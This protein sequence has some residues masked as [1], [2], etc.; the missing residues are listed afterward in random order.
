MNKFANCNSLVEMYKVMTAPGVS[1]ASL[2]AEEKETVYK[3]YFD[4]NGPGAA[5]LRTPLTEDGYKHILEQVTAYA[6]M[7]YAEA[8]KLKKRSKLHQA[9]DTMYQ[10]TANAVGSA[11]VRVGGDANEF[12]ETCDTSITNIKGAL[13][14]VLTLLDDLTGA[15][16]LKDQLMTIIYRNTEGIK[17]RR[18]F[19][20]CA[21]E[22]RKA[23]E[24][25]IRTLMALNPDEQ[26][27]KT[28]VALRYML[29]EDEEGKP[30]GRRSIFEV[31]ANGIVWICKKVT[32]KLREWFGTDAESNIFGS[33]GAAI[34][35]V[36]GVACGIIKDV[37]KVA[38]H[39]V[40][41]VGSYVLSALLN[42][43]AWVVEKISGWA[44]KAKA[45]FTP[46]DKVADDKLNQEL[47][48]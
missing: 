11:V 35:S 33:V 24:G 29:G 22:A 18:G 43:I 27:L 10:T 30:T 15:T 7:L 42:A 4:N 47:A 1:Y 12:K 44:A 45:K 19:F 46:A 3:L 31:F 25:Y 5:L 16:Y 17:S 9:V 34:A 21:E 37:A 40:I 32:R 2:N 39:F 23:V 28:V 36:F 8:K 14:V 13:G 48:A 38:I 41:Y 6:N 26:E 20:D